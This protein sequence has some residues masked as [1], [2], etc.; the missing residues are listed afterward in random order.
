VL[1]VVDKART[2]SATDF[3]WG[4]EQCHGLAIL[5]CNPP[6]SCLINILTSKVNNYS[7]RPR[8]GPISNIVRRGSHLAVAPKTLSTKRTDI[9]AKL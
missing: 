9:R 5:N 2:H 7:K 4:I 3:R 6:Y 8:S 1:L